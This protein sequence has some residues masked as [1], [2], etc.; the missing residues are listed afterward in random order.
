MIPLCDTLTVLGYR[1]EDDSWETDGCRTFIHDDDATQPFV[2]FVG[3][4][5]QRQGWQWR[6]F[7]GL[8]SPFSNIVCLRSFAHPSGQ[9]IEI[10][11]GGADCQG[12]YLHHMKASVLA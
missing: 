5:L 3:D 10:E 11:P 6:R 12:H 1:P 9:I 7:R 4:I 2:K 8:H